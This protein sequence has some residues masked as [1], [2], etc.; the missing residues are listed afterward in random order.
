MEL[1]FFNPEHCNKDVRESLLLG[2]VS[3]KGDIAVVSDGINSIEVTTNK[4]SVSKK[5]TKQE[6]VATLETNCLYVFKDCSMKMNEIGN[7][8][9]FELHYAGF[10][11]VMPTYFVTKDKSFKPLN[12]DLSIKD[13]N[14]LKRKVC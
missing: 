6:G 9:E 14:M 11:L 7:S 8:I 13:Y 1:S 10:D 4:K 5:K 3:F 2:V 12:T